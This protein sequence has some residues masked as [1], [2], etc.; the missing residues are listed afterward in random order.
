MV[1]AATYTENLIINKSLKMIGSSASTTIIDGGASNTVVMI[2]N[3]TA[4]VTVSK[5]TIRNGHAGPAS[6]SLV[7]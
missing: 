5:L 7:T 3:T 1:A 2:T 6:V 4:R